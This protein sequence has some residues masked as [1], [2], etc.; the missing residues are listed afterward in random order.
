[1]KLRRAARRTTEAVP[2][3]AMRLVK[4]AF[5]VVMSRMTRRSA[6]SLPEGSLMGSAKTRQSLPS[7]ARS[8]SV[9]S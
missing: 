7:Q 2:A 8:C 9:S 6:I 3:R 1:M 4:A 5:S